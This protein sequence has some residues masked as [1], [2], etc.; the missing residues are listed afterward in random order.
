MLK[1][2]C[3]YQYIGGCLM[4]FRLSLTLLSCLAF[5]LY[6]PNQASA[7]GNQALVNQIKTEY[8]T[9]DAAIKNQYR[10]D[11][12]TIK[13][14][15]QQFDSQVK[16]D[17]NQLKN[18]AT[19]HY[20]QLKDKYSSNEM[21]E[22]YGEIY[23]SGLALDVYYGEVYRSGLALDQY[24]GQVYRSG[25]PLDQYYG[26]VYRSGL[27]LDRYYGEVYR[28][29]LTLDTYE[30]QGGNAATL[31]QKFASIKSAAN[32]SLTSKRKAALESVQAARTAA[33]KT[34][35]QT[36]LET[37]RKLVAV[38]KELTGKETDYGTF[39]ID[40][41][42][43]EP[44]IV[45]VDK[46]ELNLSPAATMVQGTPFVPIKPI[47]EALGAT[48]T[49]NQADQSITVTAG[50]TNAVLRVNQKQAFVNGAAIPLNAPVQIIQGA[51]MMPVSFLENSL[52]ADVMVNLSI[53]VIHIN[54][55]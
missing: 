11:E 27:A 17:Y 53:R 28:T 5:M 13:A 43:N 4:H 39:G 23:R 30:R 55:K 48:V 36:K 3:F 54:T 33:I 25:L 45:K 41:L 14:A 1:F 38:E 49:W 18:I 51:A 22:L 9:Y 35:C 21:D 42:C 24:Y 40:G 34:V 2:T 26:E 37:I 19:S 10:T 8:R 6:L 12:S 46:N 44:L 31:K 15:Y 16:A 29:S 52:G 50:S 47:Y 32:Q 20:N 7:A